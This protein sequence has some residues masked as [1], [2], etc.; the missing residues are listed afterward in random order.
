MIKCNDIKTQKK[1]NKAMN[2]AVEAQL[3][4][5]KEN[6]DRNLTNFIKKTEIQ[7]KDQKDCGCNDEMRTFCEEHYREYVSGIKVGENK[8]KAY[9]FGYEEARQQVKK[10][11]IEKIKKMKKYPPN[12]KQNVNYLRTEEN[13]IGDKKLDQVIREIEGVE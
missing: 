4:K 1:I 2:K 12:N 13:R 8:R 7:P 9:Q 10:D 5:D 6:R 3:K 11:L